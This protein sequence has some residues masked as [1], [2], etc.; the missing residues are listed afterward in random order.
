MNHVHIGK[1]II[2]PIYSKED[3][4]IAIENIEYNTKKKVITVNADK[5]VKFSGVIHCITKTF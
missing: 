2:V 1:Y 5:L 4:K 3:N